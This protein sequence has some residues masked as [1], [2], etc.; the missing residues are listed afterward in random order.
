[1]LVMPEDTKIAEK[2]LV[3]NSYSCDP[4]LQETDIDGDWMRP[5]T[6]CELSVWKRSVCERGDRLVITQFTVFSE[7]RNVAQ[8]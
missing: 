3:V 2:D 4:R 7:T 6:G 8:K 5:R 1:M